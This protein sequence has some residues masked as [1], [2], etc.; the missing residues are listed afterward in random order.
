LILLKNYEA[1]LAI[2][3]NVM[4]YFTRIAASC[5]LIP[6]KQRIEKRGA[7]IAKKNHQIPPNPWKAPKLYQT[8]ILYYNSFIKNSLNEF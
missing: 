1:E 3:S 4:Q 6:Y 5:D 8:L 2:K 7:Q